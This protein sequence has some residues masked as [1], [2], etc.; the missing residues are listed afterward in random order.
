MKRCLLLG[1]LVSLWSAWAW[2]LEPVG[3]R[4]DSTGSYPQA[5]P[6]RIW[7]TEKN[8]VWRTKMP[9]WSNAT[10]VIVNDKIFVCS[11]PGT[12]VCVNLADGKILWQKENSYQD[13]ALSPEQKKQLEAEQK[14]SDEILKQI[15]EIDMQ[16]AALRKTLQ[17]NPDKKEELQ[18]KL[19]EHKTQSDALKLKLKDFP[20]AGK[21]RTPHKDGTGG[22][23]SPTPVSNGRQVFVEFGNGLVACYDMEGSR[24]WLQLIEHSTATYGHGSSPL[25][26]GNKLI[27]HFADLVALD[28]KDGSESWRVKIPPIYGTPI[29]TKVGDVDIAI[30]PNGHLIR[31]TDGAILADKLGTVGP[32]SPILHDGVMYFIHPDARAV[33]MPADLSAPAKPE[34]LWKSRLTGG[35]YWFASPIC[36]EGLV[37]ASMRW[38]S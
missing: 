9:S 36:H 22:W 28:I 33:K 7:S 11:E 14:P 30:T 17:M 31:V 34:M 5:T 29:H 27:V 37:T 2:A 35:G 15:K 32:N 25:L 10:P 8:V 6:P 1:L 24:Q 4:T 20:L 38:V 26:V 3:W 12:L 19:D 21:F 23:A 13:V 16:T 18:K